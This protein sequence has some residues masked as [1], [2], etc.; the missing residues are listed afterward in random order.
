MK[1]KFLAWTCA[2]AMSLT[3]AA[4]TDNYWQG[5]DGGSWSSPDNWS[6]GRVPTADDNT[7]LAN[8]GGPYTINVEGDQR[9]YCLM[10]G[11]ETEATVQGTV[12]LTGSGTITAVGSLQYK[13]LVMEFC[14]NGMDAFLQA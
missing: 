8:M 3:A 11:L 13:A 6:L 1:V 10:V 7:I 9:I 2:M 12:T 5:P 14:Q 4:Y